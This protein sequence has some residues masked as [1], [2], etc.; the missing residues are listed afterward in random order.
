MLLGAA[1]QAS[2]LDAAGP[3]ESDTTGLMPRPVTSEGIL[4]PAAAF[5]GG[6]LMFGSALAARYAY[7]HDFKV[8]S[9]PEASD[10]A[11]DYLRFAP[12]A[13]PWVM[14]LA[15]QPTRSGWGRMAVSQAFAGALTAGAVYS[16]KHGVE[17]PRPDNSNSNSLPSGHTA[18][19]FMGA[20]MM[21]HELGWRSPWYTVGAYAFATGIALERVFDSH[22]FPTDVM[23]GAGIGIMATEIGYYIGDLIF[24]NRQLDCRYR[25]SRDLRLNS[26]FSY[27]SLSTGLSLPIGRVR[28]GGTVISRLPALS[29][30]VRGGWAIDDNWGLAVELGLLSTPLLTDVDGYRTY[31]KSLSSLG[32]MVMPYFNHVVNSHFSLSAEIGGGYRHNFALNALDNAI[33]TGGGTPVGRVMFG[34]GLRLSNHFTARAGVG[35]EISRYDFTVHPSTAYMTTATSSCRG[36]SSSLLLNISSRY[37]F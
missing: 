31:V 19:A 34:V 8:N 20:T 5:G 37:E 13:L 11:T 10:R 21:A 22:H 18:I 27:L 24:G 28:A 1:P 4:R 14:K 36:T 7:P 2:A 9:R 23:A 15:G 29:A 33:E 3:A 32:V 17:S 25:H 6:A 26:N 12:A 16:L 30:A 35:Y